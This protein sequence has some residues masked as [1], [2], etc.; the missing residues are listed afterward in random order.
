MNIYT[1]YKATNKIN[2]KCYIG[3]TNNLNLRKLDH[4]H[5]SITKKLN[6]CFYNAINKYGWDNF[7][8]EILYQSKDRNY[9]LSIMEPH[10]I[11]EYNSYIHFQDSNGYNMTLGGECSNNSSKISKEKIASS[12]RKTRYY[13]NEHNQVFEVKNLSEFCVQHE[14]SFYAMAD[15]WLDKQI[16]HKGWKKYQGKYQNYIPNL[17]KKYKLISPDNKILEIKNLKNFC[18]NN[19]LNYNCIQKVVDK[20]TKNSKG[21]RLYEY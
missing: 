3:F 19:N 10:F 4:K 12:K 9:T 17:G 13:I 18:K 11:R 14:L 1:I 20:T 7:E 5:S 8:W 21:W 15:I 6:N 2:N 16:S